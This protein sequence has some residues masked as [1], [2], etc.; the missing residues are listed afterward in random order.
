MSTRTPSLAH[1]DAFSEILRKETDRACGVLGAALLE[2]KLQLLFKRRLRNSQD[3]LLGPL[4]PLGSFSAR[5]RTAH[6][7]AWISDDAARD[8][9]TVRN[10]RNKFAHSFDHTLGFG[11]QSIADL[12]GNLKA[13]QAYIH[14]HD[15][16]NSPMRKNFSEAVIRSM[17]DA[18]SS[19]RWRYELT[20]TFVAQH[21]DDIQGDS[22]LY[23]GPDLLAECYALSATSRLIFKAEGTSQ[24]PETN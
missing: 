21:L 20:V 12:C 11:N 4:R 13:A 2:E 24:L 16:P 7:L 1:L 6:S 9:D 3:E 19:P 10:I 5:I 15:D 22:S 23:A 14:G 17:R 18:V 8:L